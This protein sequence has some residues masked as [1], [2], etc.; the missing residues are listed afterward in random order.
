QKRSPRSASFTLRRRTSTGKP[1]CPA[2]SRRSEAT[3]WGSERC[4]G[5]T[6]SRACRSKNSRP[7]SRAGQVDHKPDSHVFSCFAGVAKRHDHSVI[8]KTQSRN[9]KLDFR[10]G[11]KRGG[12]VLI[13]ALTDN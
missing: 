4:P 3:I 13:S 2:C 11:K 1:I 10:T 12:L 9:Q 5:Q 7:S 6:Q 8:D